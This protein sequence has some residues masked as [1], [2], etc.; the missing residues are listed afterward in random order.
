MGKVR[1]RE[2]N[3]S[4]ISVSGLWG[5]FLKW[6][7]AWKKP[8]YNLITNNHHN[9]PSEGVQVADETNFKIAPQDSHSTL[10]TATFTH[11]FL[12]QARELAA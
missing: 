12:A 5:P 3:R 2:K 10:S 6:M 7:M 11:P 8:F 4:G 1:K 9:S